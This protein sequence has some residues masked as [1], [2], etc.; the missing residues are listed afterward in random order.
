MSHASTTK[1]PRRFIVVGSYAREPSSREEIGS[2][3]SL[4]GDDDAV[5][6]DARGFHVEAVEAVVHRKNFVGQWRDASHFIAVTRGELARGAERQ[7]EQARG[8]ERSHASAVL[9]RTVYADPDRALRSTLA[10]PQP[11]RANAAT[12]ST[13]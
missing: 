11:E 6:G 3:L 1:D 5:S 9:R 4:I 2:A 7:P 10:A 8:I 13:A 12:A